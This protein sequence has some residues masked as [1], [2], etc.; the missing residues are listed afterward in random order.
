MIM[1][2]YLLIINKNNN[3]TCSSILILRSL[4]NGGGEFIRR[5]FSYEFRNGNGSGLVLADYNTHKLDD[6]VL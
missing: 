2:G 6:E 4:K 1:I 5:I 3:F